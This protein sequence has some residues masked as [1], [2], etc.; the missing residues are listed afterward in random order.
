M[1]K[2]KHLAPDYDDILRE[3]STLEA[4][5]AAMKMGIVEQIT[6]EMKKQNLSPTEMIKRIGTS[7]AAFVRVLDPEDYSVTLLMLYRTAAAL[8]KSLEIRFIKNSF[9]KEGI[10]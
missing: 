3:E 5:L 2:N 7:K 9:S 1:T 10:D 6:Q 4:E 8:G